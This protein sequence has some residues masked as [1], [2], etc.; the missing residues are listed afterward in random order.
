MAIEI[1]NLV[2]RGTFGDSN[3]TDSGMSEDEL[4]T[5][6]NRLRKEFRESIA[7]EIAAS[8]QRIK[9]GLLS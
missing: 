3:P 2:V 9:E 8:E 7:K 6:T 1:G 5:I 4:R